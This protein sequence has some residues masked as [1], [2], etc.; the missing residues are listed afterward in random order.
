MYRFGV[1]N[2]IITDNGTQFTV[3]EFKNFCA[4]LGIK[5]NYALVSHPQSN[6]QAERSNGMILPGLK[7][8]IFDK[9]KP[10][11]GRWVK[12]LPTVLLALRTT[13]SHATGHTP[14]SLVYGSKAMLPTEVEHKSFLVQHFN[15]ERLDNSRADDL[16]KLEE[17]HEAAVI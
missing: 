7:P 1:P 6:G 8:R 2:N 14:F 9:L 3:S 17:L 16:N 11:A 13:P 12:E 10:Y 4:D 5:I 15:E